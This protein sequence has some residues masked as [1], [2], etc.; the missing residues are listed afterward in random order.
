MDSNG[1][2][3]HINTGI[4]YIVWKGRFEE[5]ILLTLNHIRELIQL[6]AQEYDKGL[7]QGLPEG[8]RY[9]KKNMFKEVPEELRDAYIHN[10]KALS[11]DLF[12]WLIVGQLAFRSLQQQ[13]K[14]YINENEADNLA[15]AITN[16]SLSLGAS[17]L[18]TSVMDFN[19]LESIGGRGIDW[20]P[21]S[22]SMMTNTYNN[23]RN[24][25]TG[26]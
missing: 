9:M 17:L 24:F 20:T 19:F 16:N 26:S 18:K 22:I 2:R 3:T 14:S 13:A 21:F 7:I 10:L 6:G 8:I 12:V 23:W 25:L 15:Q 11:Y 5:G 4:A 1:K